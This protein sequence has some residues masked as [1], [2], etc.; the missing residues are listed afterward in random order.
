MREENTNREMEQIKAAIKKIE[1]ETLRLKVKCRLVGGE[2]VKSMLLNDYVEKQ[3]SEEE[4]DAIADKMI[5]AS[6]NSEERSYLENVESYLENVEL[7]NELQGLI[8]EIRSEESIDGSYSFFVYVKPGLSFVEFKEDGFVDYVYP[9]SAFSKTYLKNVVDNTNT[10]D[11]CKNLKHFATNLFYL[12]REKLHKKAPI[13]I[14]EHIKQTGENNA[15]SRYH[16]WLAEYQNSCRIFEKEETQKNKERMEF[17]K[18]G[19]AKEWDTM[20]IQLCLA[21]SE[22][23]IEEAK[24]LL[25][26]LESLQSRGE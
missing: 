25:K 11:R 10:E 20:K 23:L 14:D 22:A 2:I 16:L 1:E 6:K 5:E 7:A 4:L 17:A 19:V 26:E 15:E 8:K 9:R 3:Y 13:D 12:H 21:K 24:G 18:K